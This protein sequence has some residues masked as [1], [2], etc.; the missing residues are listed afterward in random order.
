MQEAGIGRESCARA[1]GN[2]KSN[3]KVYLMSVVV[4]VTYLYLSVKI[5]QVAHLKL[6]NVT[7]CKLFLNKDDK[8]K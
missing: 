4:V 2:L 1:Q 7:V 8:K 3:A 5:H 6:V